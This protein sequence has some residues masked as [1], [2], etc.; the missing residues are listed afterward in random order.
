MN[1][2]KLNKPKVLVNL[3]NVFYIQLKGP[4]INIQANYE[5]GIEV[6]FDNEEDAIESFKNISEQ[7]GYK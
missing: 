5:S 4:T 7:L 3:D 1:Y 2:I 6:N